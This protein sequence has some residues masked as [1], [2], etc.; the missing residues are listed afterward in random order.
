MNR[1]WHQL[2]EPFRTDLAAQLTE[3]ELSYLTN[4]LGECYD[5]FHKIYYEIIPLLAATPPD[6]LDRLHECVYGIGGVGGA[7]VDVEEQVIASRS[8]FDVLLRILAERAERQQRG[9]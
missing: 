8:G 4:V 1:L 5:R 2:L 9:Q 3:L 6:D 7:L